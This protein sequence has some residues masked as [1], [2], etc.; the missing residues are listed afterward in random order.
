[1]ETASRLAARMAFRCP[2]IHCSPCNTRRCCGCANYSVG[3]PAANEIQLPATRDAS[4]E[5][6]PGTFVAMP[7]AAGRG[8]GILGGTRLEEVG[9]FNTVEHGGQPGQWVLLHAIDLRQP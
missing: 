4:I 8:L 7:G 5:Q 3:V 6:P 1:M 9:V 2:K